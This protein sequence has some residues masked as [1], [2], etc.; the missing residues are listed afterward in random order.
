MLG[1]GEENAITVNLKADLRATGRATGMYFELDLPVYRVQHE[2][3]TRLSQEEIE[4]L[5]GNETDIVR[6][7]VK[8]APANP[9]LWDGFSSEEAYWG[10]G[11]RIY[12]NG[13]IESG[14]QE[15]VEA[16]LYFDGPM[17]EN[18]A[19]VVKLGG[20]YEKYTYNDVDHPSFCLL[21]TSDAADE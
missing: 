17:P 16:K 21:Y 13:R 3:M 10:N 5:T 2:S 6:V 19:A 12:R 4:Q 9:D 7:M 8:F 14:K 1:H 15:I 20:G 18:S 11:V